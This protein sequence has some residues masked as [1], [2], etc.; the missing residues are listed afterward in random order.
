MKGFHPDEVND[1]LAALTAEG[2]LSERRFAESYVY[3]RMEK[4]Y[5]PLRIQHELRERGI[6][7]ILVTD[8]LAADESEWLQ[9]LEKVR[10]KRFGAPFPADVREKRR[11]WQFLQYRGFTIGQIRRALRDND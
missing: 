5:G 7:E 11:Q 10:K 4:G 9:R 6:D 1:V 8:C 2:L 3:Q